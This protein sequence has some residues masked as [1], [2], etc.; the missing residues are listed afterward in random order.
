MIY[1]K[2]SDVFSAARVLLGTFPKNPD[3]AQWFRPALGMADRISSFVGE[4]HLEL[5]LDTEGNLFVANDGF[6]EEV[7]QMMNNVIYGLFFSGDNNR[8]PFLADY[9]PLR[10]QVP[11]Y[12]RAPFIANKIVNGDIH[13]M[14]FLAGMLDLSFNL[15]V[16]NS[17]ALPE[18]PAPARICLVRHSV[19]NDEPPAWALETI[20]PAGTQVVLYR[21]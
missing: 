14:M 18:C 19:R 16:G 11:Y 13:H 9:E 10:P 15:R 1:C 3:Y 2:L 7:R 5:A 20:D 12:S 21:A 6:T 17:K 4:R 8:G